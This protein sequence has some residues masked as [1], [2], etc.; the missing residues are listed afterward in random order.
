MIILIEKYKIKL[1]TNYKIDIC[2]QI[3]AFNHIS[4]LLLIIII[5]III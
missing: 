1:I 5:K 3:I 4:S 2:M